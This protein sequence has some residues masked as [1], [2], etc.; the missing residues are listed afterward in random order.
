MENDKQYRTL[1]E[2]LLSVKN[3][4]KKFM[5]ELEREEEF[6]RVESIDA[7]MN[8]IKLDKEIT[9]NQ[10]NKFIGQIKSG[11][12]NKIKTNPNDVIIHKPSFFQRIKIAFYNLFKKF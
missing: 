10:K 6:E 7:I 2:I 3:Q 9:K 4:N 8:G 5:E 11:L 12:G 1:E